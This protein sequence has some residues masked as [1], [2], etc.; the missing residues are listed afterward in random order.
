MFLD[1]YVQVPVSASRGYIVDE[2]PDSALS[3]Q[4]RQVCAM[5]DPVGMVLLFEE[6]RRLLRNSGSG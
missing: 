3:I 6:E 5:C 2:M 1:L 4:Y